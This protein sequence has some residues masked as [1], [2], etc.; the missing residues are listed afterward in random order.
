MA[1]TRPA[2]TTST[3]R[4]ERRSTTAAPVSD[5]RSSDRASEAA[6]ASG[7]NRGGT[8]DR[9][10]PPAG[11]MAPA[12]RKAATM[13]AARSGSHPAVAAASGSERLPSSSA[14]RRS[15]AAVRPSMTWARR[16]SMPTCRLFSDRQSRRSAGLIAGFGSSRYAER[17]SGRESGVSGLS[18]PARG[19]CNGRLVIESGTVGAP[20]TLAPSP[21]GRA[22]RT[23]PPA[24]PDIAAATVSDVIHRPLLL[25]GSRIDGWTGRWE[26]RR[27]A[28]WE[29]VRRLAMGLPEVV[30]TGTVG[31]NLAWTVRGK[32]FAWERPLRKSDLAAL[33]P[34][35]P[36]GPVLG[37]K[38]A[39][40]DAKDAMLAADPRVVF[41]TPHFTGYP[42]VLVDLSAA[43]VELLEELIPE[44]WL[45]KAPKRL[46]KEFL[47]ATGG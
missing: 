29:D 19:T 32:M 5:D 4:S 39:D 35:A 3:R 20:T 34:A 15:S 40:L 17:R 36:D 24:Q 12:R 1:P 46:A 23:V 44:A 45:S 11:A 8:A 13:L 30:E 28:S 42:A 31:G 26:I 21:Y 33:G 9:S 37:L 25:G 14:S 27:V 18:V 22:A 47:A 2:P 38:T 16:G 41:T 10:L 7:C 43:G 6:S